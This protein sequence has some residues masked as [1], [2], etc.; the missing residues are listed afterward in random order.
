MPFARPT[1]RE[2]RRANGPPPYQPSPSGWVSKQQKNKGLKARSIYP[3]NGT[4][5]QPSA[6]SLKQKPSPLGW[7]GMKTGRWPSEP[8]FPATHIKSHSPHPAF[9]SLECFLKN[10]HAVTMP[11]G[12]I[13][14]HA[15]RVKS[16]T[17]T[18][19]LRCAT[20]WQDSSMML[21]HAAAS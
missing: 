10:P 3:E 9:V 11:S 2:A 15:P 14:F 17:S 6:F 18:G 1:P 13:V 12:L 16:G 7:A 19:A 4:G 21:L 5:L 20:D 8:A